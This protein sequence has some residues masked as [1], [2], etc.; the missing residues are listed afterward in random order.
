MTVLC[1]VLN[2]P[3]GCAGDEVACP[4][5][6]QLLLEQ[7]PGEG[8]APAQGILGSAAATFPL[9][10]TRASGLPRFVTSSGSPVRATS[11]SIARQWA[12]N[13]EMATDFI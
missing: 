11:S 12:L 10:V 2:L 3:L 7:V 9:G 13:S 1:Q 5:L 6:A 8:H 4:L